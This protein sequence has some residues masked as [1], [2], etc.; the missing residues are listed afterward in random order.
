VNRYG[1][2]IDINPGQIDI[3]PLYVKDLNWDSIPSDGCLVYDGTGGG[4]VDYTSKMDDTEAHQKL[5]YAVMNG[6]TIAF[7]GGVLRRMEEYYGGTA[8][9]TMLKEMFQAETWTNSERPGLATHNLTFD[10]AFDPRDLAGSVPTGYWTELESSSTAN[11][12]MGDFPYAGLYEAQ[13][14]TGKVIGFTRSSNPFKTLFTDPES[15]TYGDEY[16]VRFFE[17]CSGNRGGFRLWDVG[18]TFVYKAEGSTYYDVYYALLVE[19]YGFSRDVPL[20]VYGPNKPVI[21]NMDTNEV[22]SNNSI[23]HLEQDSSMLFKIK[24]KKN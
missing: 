9:P 2:T 7:S 13:F 20:V 12:I 3:Y 23:I 22:I 4:V 14:G 17:Y 10:G 1:P 18:K 16:S 6:S 24:V 5:V 15:A 21:I 19:R 8:I 11:I